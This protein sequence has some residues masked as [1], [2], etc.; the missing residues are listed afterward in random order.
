MMAGARSMD[1]MPKYPLIDL[2]DLVGLSLIEVR[3]NDPDNID[4]FISFLTSSGDRL[5]FFHREDCCER[6]WLEDV[7]GDL[8]DLLRGPITLAEYVTQEDGD[9]PDCGWTFYKFATVAGSVTLRFCGESE[10]YA[11]DVDF[12]WS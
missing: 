3:R 11:I 10:F 9:D 7:C 2:A 8:D 4:D 12:K 6:V 1:T 5:T